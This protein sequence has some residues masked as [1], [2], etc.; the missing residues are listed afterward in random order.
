MENSNLIHYSKSLSGEHKEH[1]M[2]RLKIENQIIFGDINEF[3][4]KYPKNIHN[5]K[6][7]TAKTIYR[8]IQTIIFMKNLKRI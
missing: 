7:L 5:K 1:M 2:E 3:E 8:K 6:Q 4:N